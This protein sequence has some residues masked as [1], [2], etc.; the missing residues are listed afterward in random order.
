MTL[1]M[2]DPHRGPCIGNA[3][4]SEPAIFFAET[5]RAEQCAKVI[6]A[7]CSIQATRLEPARA[8]QEPCGVWGGTTARVGF[9][10]D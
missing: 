2:D 7:N 9:V 3:S 5:A 6:C 8:N 10:G 4:S 1:T